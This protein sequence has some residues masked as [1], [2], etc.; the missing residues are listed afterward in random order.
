M[1]CL[2]FDNV[3]KPHLQIFIPSPREHTTFV[4]KPLFEQTIS[5]LYMLL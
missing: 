3:N 2:L 1:K 5:I 4:K